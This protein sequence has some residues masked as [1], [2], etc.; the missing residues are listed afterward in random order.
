MSSVRNWL[1]ENVLKPVETFSNGA[2]RDIEKAAYDYQ[3]NVDVFAGKVSGKNA[4]DVNVKDRSIALLSLFASALP[5]ACSPAPAGNAKGPCDWIDCNGHGTCYETSADYYCKCDDGYENV[6]GTCIPGQKNDV[7]EDVITNKEV[8]ENKEVFDNGNYIGLDI[9]EGDEVSI[10]TPPDLSGY[11]PE[12]LCIEFGLNSC[13]NDKS[14]IMCYNPAAKPPHRYQTV[15][16]PDDQVCK[17]GNCVVPDTVVDP[18]CGGENH[19]ACK[20]TDIVEFSEYTASTHD[21]DYYCDMPCADDTGPKMS[22]YQEG[23]FK[24][25]SMDSYACESDPTVAL[26][27]TL[28]VSGNDTWLKFDMG[29]TPPPKASYYKLDTKLGWFSDIAGWVPELSIYFGDDL[30]RV[31]PFSDVWVKCIYNYLTDFGTE[32]INSNVVRINLVNSGAL[33]EDAVAGGAYD[34]YYSTVCTNWKYKK[35]LAYFAKVRIWSCECK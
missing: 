31:V 7:H 26:P 4:Q 5:F 28:E 27:A 33:G 10:D 18:K 34:E 8:I 12:N 15:D 3:E 32:G 35:R 20:V 22:Y 11:S 21:I 13:L 2:V 17:D 29:I 25:Y 9:I 16:C 1:S 23:C 6:G 19:S 24:K 30:K 14:A